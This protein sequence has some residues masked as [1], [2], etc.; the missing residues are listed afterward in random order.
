MQNEST[1]GA[2]G[3]VFCG[4]DTHADSHWLCVLDWRGR[5]VLSRQFPA[6]AAGYEALAGAIAAAGEPAC[7]AMEGTSSYGAGLTR[8]LASLGMP[9]RE[10]LSPARMQRRRPG[11]GKCDESDAERAARAAMSGS[12]LGTPK[13]QDGWVDGVRCMLAAR[14]GAVK[15]RTS[16]INTARSLLTTAPEGLRSR[17]RGMAGPRLME[18]LPSVRAEGALGAALGAL[19]DLWA[20]ARDAALDMERAIEAS[21]EENCP[22]LLA[23]YGRGPVSAAKLAVAAGDNPGRLRSEAS[24]AAICGACPI[25][26]SSGKTVRHRLNRGGD[27]QAN[28]ALH[29]IARQ[30]VMRDPETAEYAERARARGEERQGGHEVPQALRGQ[31]GVPGADAPARGQEARGRLGARGGQARGEGQPGEGGVHT[32]HQREV[33]LDAGEGPKGAQAHKEGLRGMGRGRTSARLEQAG[34]RG[35]AQNGF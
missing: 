3:P 12:R 4:V 35:R 17:F 8:H 34:L 30:R 18:E 31:G 19:A 25:P 6:D 5:K 16:A 26:A 29:E 22:A 7:V 10:A 11:Q 2:R 32:G 14:S 28:S 1:P 27:R 9:V 24:F 15:A 33:H 20:A 23:M 13:S 21:L